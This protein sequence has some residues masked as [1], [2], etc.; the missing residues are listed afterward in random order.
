LLKIERDLVETK[1]LLKTF[2]MKYD[3]FASE[4]TTKFSDFEYAM[5]E[6]EKNI[7]PSPSDE[8]NKQNVESTA[9]VQSE[10]SD[11]NDTN[12]MSVDL[13]N[14]IKQEFTSISIE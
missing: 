14:I 11:M 9:V 13:K 5:S 8:L 7:Q 10:E 6:L 4:T 3:A 1:D 12:I 2:M